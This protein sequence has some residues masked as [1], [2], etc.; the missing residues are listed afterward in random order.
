[1]DIRL[2]A[3]RDEV[4]ATGIIS[5]GNYSAGTGSIVGTSPSGANPV[6]ALIV[7][8]T[9]VTAGNKPLG[10]VIALTSGSVQIAPLQNNISIGDYFFV[11]RQ[12]TYEM[13]L[14][15]NPSVSLNYQ[16]ADIKEPEK[17]KASY[18]QTFKLP[19]TDNN[20]QF[21]QNWYNV[22]LT[23]LIFNTREKFNAVLFVGT[24]PQ[25]EGIIELK[26]VYH[27]AQ[28]YEI[29]L[30]SNSADLFTLIGNNKLKDVFLND[31][32]SYSKELNHLF[33]S[34]NI[35]ESWDGTSTSF[36]NVPNGESLRDADSSVQKVMYPLNVTRPKFYYDGV[37]SNQYLAMDNPAAYSNDVQNDNRVDITQ[38]RPS[39]QIKELFKLIIARAGFSYTSTFIDGDYFGKLYMTTCNHIVLPVTPTLSSTGQETGNMIVGNTTSDWG[40]YDNYNDCGEQPNWTICPANQ[41]TPI[42]TFTFPTDSENIWNESNNSFEVLDTNMTMIN[43]KFNLEGTNIEECDGDMRLN[44]RIQGDNGS[45][46]INWNLNYSNGN[47]PLSTNINTG[48]LTTTEV[49]IDISL[50]WMEPGDKAFILFKPINFK[51][52]NPTINSTLRLGSSTNDT[53]GGM[54]NLITLN[55]VGYGTNIYNRTVDIPSCIDDKITQKAFLKDLISRFNLVVLSDP[56][57]ANNIIVETYNDYLSQGSIKYWTKKLDLSKEII[58]KDTTT[59]Q[60]NSIL[61]SDLED[62]DMWNKSI[63]EE[64]PTYNPYG[65]IEITETNNEFSNGKMKNDSLFS[66]YINEKVFRNQ[67]DQL[68]TL[69]RNVVVHYDYTYS[70][71]APNIEN[72]LEATNPKL[73]YYSG[74]PS[75]LQVSGSASNNYYLHRANTSGG[76]FAIEFTSF[77]LCTPYELTVDVNGEATLGV[78]TRSLYWNQAPPVAGNLNCFNYNQNS[79]LGTRS[80]YYEYWESYLNSIYHID[81]R[82]MECYLN[83]DSVDILNFKFSDEIFIKDNYWRILNISNYQV[84][85]EVSTKVTLLK[86]SEFY[87]DTCDTCNYIP[88][89]YNGQNTAGPWFIWC[90]TDNPNCTPLLV[91]PFTNLYADEQSCLAAG[92]TPFTG[93]SLYAPLYLCQAN[94]G[95]L[96]INLTTIFSP[97]S[98]FSTNSTKSLIGGKV[99]GYNR[100]LIIGNDNNK[101]SQ[102]LLPHYGNDIV[103]K[104]N[105][106]PKSTPQLSGESHKLILSGFTIANTKSYAYVQG[107][108]TQEVLQILTESNIMLRVK[109]VSTV[110]GGSSATYPV[111]S[112]EA[113]AYYTAFKN[114]GS[115][116]VQLGT[117]G[118]TAEFS[119]KESGAGSVCSLYIDIVSGVLRFGLQDS[120]TDTKRIWQLSVQ[121]DV[122]LIENISIPYD[123]N[124]ALFQNQRNIE[125]E[126][127][128]YLIWN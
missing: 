106:N 45:G 63:K 118:G 91:P 49:N 26:S 42:T 68:P 31:N 58:V 53:L 102:S 15:G 52:K 85:G 101:Y 23:T 110:I 32:G 114:M 16:F 92:G 46:G 59:M 109:G 107:D 100:P 12:E 126:N 86:A 79:V 21:F 6:V 95:S 35:K 2:V 33:S 117:A 56:N 115:T 103:I 74:V 108:E 47:I 4:V 48:A 24:V 93:L 29:L 25:F 128:D 70:G 99:N 66:P 64:Q 97:K 19:F 38:L 88:T 73:F 125:F 1:M 78:N 36:V 90:P 71:T 5:A 94:T 44:Y 61:L 57:N 81:A 127:Q 120:Q 83:L 69:L 50:G 119:L 76:V 104:Y 10:T 113:F 28:V 3:Y 105:T 124:W 96:P 77:P 54:Y 65:K 89:E 13:D 98:I 7:G 20:N 43:V 75:V 121:V 80:L 67:D 116:A 39:I 37:N 17:R 123:E 72:P 30:L 18:S 9:L 111:G 122:N 51:K 34:Y 55:W 27:K 87:N 22:N 40:N 60:K 14:Q 112:T 84:S 82:I 62:V 41:V 11:I 8:D